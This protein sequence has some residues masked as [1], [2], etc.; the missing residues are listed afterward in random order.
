MYFDPF[1]YIGTTFQYDF[2]SRMAGFE[3]DISFKQEE[4]GLEMTC[5]VTTTDR[6]TLTKFCEINPKV[7]L[8]QGYTDCD[9]LPSEVQAQL[10]AVLNSPSK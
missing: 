3:A 5:S 6:E 8:V 10:I 7:W 2:R 9:N 4:D 1:F